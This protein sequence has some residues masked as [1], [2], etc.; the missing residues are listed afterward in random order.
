MIKKIDSNKTITIDDLND[1]G[2]QIIYSPDF[3]D[4]KLNMIKISKAVLKLE[5]SEIPLQKSTVYYIDDQSLKQYV[6]D[7]VSAENKKIVVDI[8]DE[9]QNCI[10]MSKN[11]IILQIDKVAK[12]SILEESSEVVLEYYF[13]KQYIKDQ[14]SYNLDA[15]KAGS[16]EINLSTGRLK[17]A[18][19]DATN[20]SNI[21]PL[22]V[23]HSFDSI[24]ADSSQIIVPFLDSYMQ[25]PRAYGKGWKINFNQFIVKENFE[26]DIPSARFTYIDADGNHI[27][28]EEKYYWKNASGEKCYIPKEKTFVNQDGKLQYLDE[29]GYYHDVIEEI[30]SDTGLS[31]ITKYEDM[32]GISLLTQDNEDIATLKDEKKSL[33][34]SHKEMTLQR[35]NNASAIKLLDLS[36][37]ISLKNQNLQ[38]N[39]LANEQE[40]INLQN[41]TKKLNEEYKTLYKKYSKLV[42][43]RAYKFKGYPADMEAKAVYPTV[44]EYD[45][46]LQ[47]EQKSDQI[48]NLSYQAKWGDGNT[49]LGTIKIR[50]NS[51]EIQKDIFEENK[52]YSSQQ[53]ELER[54]KLIEQNESLSETISEYDK[55][56]LKKDHQLKTLQEQAPEIILTDDNGNML[57]F[58]LTSQPNVFKLFAVMDN[59]ENQIN[60]IYDD[61]KIEKIIDSENNALTFVYENNLLVSLKDT[62]GR[63][64]FYKY[65][66]NQNLIEIKYPSGALCKYSYDEN[67]NLI[68]VLNDAGMGYA[69]EYEFGKVVKVEEISCTSKISNDIISPV[70]NNEIKINNCITIQYNNYDSTSITNEKTNKTTTYVFYNIGRVITK[71]E[72]V[73]ENG[74][75][76]GRVDSV[77]YERNIDKSVFIIK[78]LAYS[79]NLLLNIKSTH[80]SP[81][82]ISENYLGDGFTC[83][84]NVTTMSLNVIEDEDDDI[85]ICNTNQPIISK[86]LTSDIIQKIKNEKITD[87]VLSGWAKADA[88]WVA[89]KNTDYC[90]K[91]EENTSNNELE[92][93]LLDN[94]DTLKASR[95]FELRAELTYM[96]NSQEKTVEQY[97]SFDWMNTDWQY[98]A[99][100]VT[101][102]E[103]P[104]DELK[105][106]KVYF[107][108]SNNIGNASFYGMCL[109]RG[110]WEYSE[111]KDNLKSYAESSNSDYVIYFD[112]DDKNKLIKATAQNKNNDKQFVS[113]FTYNENGSLVRSL[114]YNGIVTE[115][116]YNDKGS[117]IRSMTYH[118]DEPANKFITTEEVDEKGQQTA[119]FNEFGEKI[120]ENTFVNKTGLLETS[121]DTNGNKVSYGYDVHDDTL[122]QM[123]TTVNDEANSNIM[124]YTGNLL[125]SLTHNNT[126]IKFEYDGFGKQTKVDVAEALYCTTEYEDIVETQI[127]ENGTTIDIVTGQK[128]TTVNAKNEK[129]IVYTDLDGN[130]TRIEFVDT[131]GLIT[132]IAENRYDSYGNLLHTKDNEMQNEIGYYYDE[133]GRVI[134]KTYTQNNTP[135]SIKNSYDKYGNVST[136]TVTIGSV[137]DSYENTYD[138]SNPEPKHI[139]TKIGNVTETY[140]YDKLSRI[141]ETQ[142][143]S[144]YSKHFNYL[145]KGNYTSNLIASEWFGK[146]GIV[147]ESLKY[148]YDQNG[149]IIKIFENGELIQNFEYDGIS[150]LIRENN[151]KLNKTTTFEYDAGGNIFRKIECGYTT[152]ATDNLSGGTVIPYTYPTSGWKDQLISYNGQ[153]ITYDAIGN[154]TL[155]LGKTLQWSHGR[156]L[157]KFDNFEYKYNA[158]GIRT[159]KTVNGVTTQYFL[160]GTKILAQSNGNC[161]KQW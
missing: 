94:M 5:L 52:Q 132:T 47:Y 89:R 85:L 111:F 101:I 69:F 118:K 14:A 4:T 32:Q 21:L 72:N 112:Y 143:G 42:D 150:R 122:L 155:Y 82:T 63:E 40:D 134:E 60:I 97:C 79:E 156:Q 121:T 131:S 126:E 51:L 34:K 145:Q 28:F 43:E 78:E 35:E 73:F 44:E 67:G 125:T 160:D 17:F 98:C 123:S 92:Q 127:L 95:R 151:K 18:F 33:M 24:D 53:Y 86:T 77:S 15:G 37:K 66:T 65:D 64:T 8:T 26:T 120:S 7:E 117:K 76:I 142:L 108:Y 152:V 161:T 100:P 105:T 45:T 129:F 109:K 71:Y 135:I 137:V 62:C 13:K 30:I 93:L 119:D 106:I 90:G 114:D 88:A 102:S 10:S 136:T 19:Q 146:N 70:S 12:S 20:N 48:E 31:L 9:L 25:F 74:S 83:G 141:S 153:N 84:E 39:S 49:K 147:Q 116:I 149:N 81:I 103:D 75:I 139:S 87:L 41:Q 154:P 133:Y 68:S 140:K 29:K 55:L 130:T 46:K 148:S 6:V 58:S 57:A 23:K 91:C 11:H 2:I 115:N 144:I 80:S 1:N 27:I 138:Y 104:Q 158:N 110:E 157:D 61:T 3:S 99:F 22:S 38:E 113:T 56:L 36:K 128:A 54:K 107:D 124:H 159:S 16:G 50:E 96:N 59:Y